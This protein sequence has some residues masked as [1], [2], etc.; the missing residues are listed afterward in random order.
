MTKP[1]VLASAS[2]RRKELLERVGLV[3]S[4]D[5]AEIQ[6]D[7]GRKMEPAELAKAISREKARSA[8]ARHPGAI[9]IAA[10]TFGVLD[11]RLLGK[12]RNAADAR[13]ML[14]EMSGREHRVFTGFTILDT[15]SGRELSRVVETAVRFRQLRE[16]EIAAYVATG[17]P[18]GKAGAYAIQ[19][20]GALL[21]EGIEGD[22]Y[23]VIG[24]PLCALAQGLKEFGVN[25]P[26]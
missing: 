23:N 10:D 15:Q 20:L 19:G 17:E 6:E 3:F 8:A 22:F 16:D 5:A 25:L 14:A 18:L 24:L 4:V 12:P 2:P 13:R 26:G 9:V 11:G 1:I 21:V 7:H